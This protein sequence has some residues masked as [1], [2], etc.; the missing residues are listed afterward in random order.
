MFIVGCSSSSAPDWYSK[1]GTKTTGYITGVGQGNSLPQAQTSALNS[2]NEVLWTEVESSF[3]MQ[4]SE[5]NLNKSTATQRY[6]DSNI[7]TKTAKLA[8]TNIDYVNSIKLGDVYFV[9]ARVSKKDII[10]RLNDDIKTT[11]LTS[12]QRLNNLKHQ[13]SLLWWLGTKDKQHELSN[14]HTKL[15]ILSTLDGKSNTDIP[16]TLKLIEVIEQT[17]SKIIIQLKAVKSDRKSQLFLSEQIANNGISSVIDDQAQSTHTLKVDS[18]YRKNKVGEAYIATKLTDITLI[19]KSGKIIAT[20]EIISTGNSVINFKYA[21]EGAE[22]HFSELIKKEGLW[23]A[24][25]IKI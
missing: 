13:D 15:T 6:I 4:E 3:S 16:Y 18:E 19:S 1:N 2:I 5:R 20:N 17:K 21:Q 24:F 22:R 25:G 10:K 12:K 14:I 23:V 11:E 9:E 7:N 8:L